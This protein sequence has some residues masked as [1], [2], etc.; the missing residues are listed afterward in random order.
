MI[1]FLSSAPAKFILF[2]EHAV[3]YGQ[4]AIAVPILDVRAYA[5]IEIDPSLPAPAIRAEDMGID[6]IMNGQNP[7]PQIEH[8]TIAIHLI[9]KRTNFNFL[10]K[11][12]KLTL[13]SEI[14]IGRGLGS[15]AAICV[16]LVK[17]LFQFCGAE[18]SVSTL[19][20]LSYELET[21]HHGT[22]SGID[23][24]VISL[25]KPIRF[26]KNSEIQVIH[27]RLFYFVIADT[28][29]AKKTSRVVAEVAKRYRDHKNS[30]DSIFNSI[31]ALSDKGADALKTGDGNFLGELMDLNQS[32]LKKIG[33]SSPELD[34]LI[35]AA[36]KN[37]ALGAKLCGAGQGGC[38][39]ALAN[40]KLQAQ[41]IQAA[42]KRSGAVRSFIT[43]LIGGEK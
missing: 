3:V 28:G 31:G 43:T 37:G 21:Y 25:E 27:P 34:R 40:D 29:I 33:V 23:N 12:W 15:S 22:P 30:Y 36:K 14:P 42:L 20:D 2:G 24:T 41:Q 7:P 11:R 18:L 4:P 35:Q 26:Q 1:N 13:R 5:K 6:F 38:L 32:H 16:A 19:I 9:S 39:V 17:V 8:L 10:N